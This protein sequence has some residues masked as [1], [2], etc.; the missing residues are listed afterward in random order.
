MIANNED[1][2]D[3]LMVGNISK[4]FSEE[5]NSTNADDE[6]DFHVENG[7][8]TAV[9]SKGRDTNRF[10]FTRIRSL[11]KMDPDLTISSQ[12][13]VFLITKAAELFV[14]LQALEAY[15]KTKQAKRKTVQKKDL[16]AAIAELDCMAFLEGAID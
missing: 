7:E 13:S 5:F 12:E 8:K 16:D 4:D 11:M 9:V 15:K 1:V 3:D 2:D 14:Q 6:D 10:P